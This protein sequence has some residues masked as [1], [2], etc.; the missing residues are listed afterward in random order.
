MIQ[1]QSIFSLLLSLLVSLTIVN[2]S[3]SS[4]S[5][6]TATPS[7]G[8]TSILTDANGQPVGQPVGANPSGDTIY[9]DA[10]GNYYVRD[11]NGNPI[12]TDRNGNPI[13]LDNTI[14][15]PL[16]GI[17]TVEGR[18]SEGVPG[19]TIVIHPTSPGITCGQWVSKQDVYQIHM[20]SLI[21]TAKGLNPMPGNQPAIHADEASLDRVCVEMGCGQAL[22]AYTREYS[23]PYNNTIVRWQSNRWIKEGAK[24]RDEDNNIKIDN[25]KGNAAIRCD[26]PGSFTAGQVRI[27]ETD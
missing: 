8:P 22:E 20:K 10:N 19:Q 15:N 13:Q 11:T 18:T 14:S 2:C 1:T 24:W 16:V 26:A 23:S 27:Y 3:K 7:S 5:A 6:N 25:K 4:F 21:N 12:V 9:V 17:I